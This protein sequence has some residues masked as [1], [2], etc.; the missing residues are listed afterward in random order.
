MNCAVNGANEAAITETSSVVLLD[1][2]ALNNDGFF[3]AEDT[4]NSTDQMTKIHNGGGN[5]L[6][7][8][9]HAKFYNFNRFPVNKSPIG[10]MLK[11]RTIGSP[12]FYD[13]GLGKPPASTYN[14]VTDVT[15]PDVGYFASAFG[16][17]VAP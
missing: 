10:Q 17:C 11:T 8:D 16:T 6:F 1:D 3:Y 7:A 9:G 14:P 2:E 4:S 12:R 13:I 15:P 5:L